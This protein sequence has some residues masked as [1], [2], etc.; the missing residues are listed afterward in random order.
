MLTVSVQ[1]SGNKI[2]MSSMID[3]RS[4]FRKLVVLAFFLLRRVQSDATELN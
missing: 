1:H 2:Y 4:G 3:V